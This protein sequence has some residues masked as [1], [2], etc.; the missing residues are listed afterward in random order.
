[1]HTHKEISNTLKYTQIH[2][3]PPGLALSIFPTH[4]VLSFRSHALSN[5]VNIISH[6]T[7]INAM[8]F[9]HL[10]HGYKLITL[11]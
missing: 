9:K 7:Y 6:T 4:P 11:F 2:L 8:T 1:M 5:N 3:I 10:P